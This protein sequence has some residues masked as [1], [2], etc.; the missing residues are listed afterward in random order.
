M[1][2][3]VSENYKNST[4][5][6]DAYTKKQKYTLCSGIESINIIKMGI[7]HR[8]IY[9]FKTIPNKIS[10]L[11][12]LEQVIPNS[13]GIISSVLSLSCVRLSAT[14][15]AAACFPVHHQLPELTQTHVH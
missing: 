3:L 4:K 11:T 8:A 10:I 5:E 6:I 2:N 1:K 7:L 13:H 12:Q 14:P 9:R 15:W